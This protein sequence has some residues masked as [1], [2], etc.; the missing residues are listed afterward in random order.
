MAVGGDVGVAAEGSAGG[1]NGLK[2][3]E[4]AL[5]SQAY[6]RA[7]IGV[8][9]EDPRWRGPDLADFVLSPFAKDEHATLVEQM[10]R[11]TSA[12]ETWLTDGIERAMN[13]HNR[14]PAG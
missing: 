9:P 8:A 3:I 4:A 5:S 10:P 1:H 7:R 11:L 2:S 6:A 13:L 14:E 12:V